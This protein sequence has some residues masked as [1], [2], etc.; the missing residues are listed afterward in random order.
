MN[1][2]PLIVVISGPSGVGKG[3][4]HAGVRRALPDAMLAVSVTTRAPRPGER[5]GV[6]YHFVSRDGF[7]HLRRSGALLEHA[8]YAG[9]WYGTPRSEVDA[10]VVGDNVVILDIEVQ[11]ALQVKRACADALLVFLTPPSV[12]VLESRLRARGTEDEAAISARLERA[13]HE[14][15]Q[16]DQFDIVVVN[17]ELERCIDEVVGAIRSAHA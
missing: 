17:D 12:E 7:D 9:Q 3:A 16:R 6:D 13:R 1:R 11:G 8:E 14:L 2:S 4:V 10:S 15:D 5:D